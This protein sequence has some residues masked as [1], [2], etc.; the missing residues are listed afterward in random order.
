M[1]DQIDKAISRLEMLIGQLMPVAESSDGTASAHLRVENA[2]LLALLRAHPPPRPQMLP[3]RRMK[4]AAQQEW[5]CALCGELLGELFHA[6]HI[7][8]WCETFDDRDG[9]IQIVH[10]SCHTLKTSEENSARNRRRPAPH[11]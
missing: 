1:S 7:T 9:N 4:L 5:R 2:R 3:Q 10:P 11:L 8:P 6:D